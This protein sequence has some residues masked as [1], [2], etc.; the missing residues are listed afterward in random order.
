MERIQA[1]L[2]YRPEEEYLRTLVALPETHRSL[3]STWIVQCEVDNG[4]F[5]QYFWNI[6][7]DGFYDEAESGFARLAASRH[8]EIFRRAR[9]IITPHLPVMRTWQG[10]NDRWSKYKRFLERKGVYDQLSRI[11]SQFDDLR[12]SLP[13]LRVKYISANAT[14]L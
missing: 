3:W 6:K 13:D 7:L 14:V 4:G 10:V 11:N 8:L 1:R 5:A 12:P 2:I 9:A